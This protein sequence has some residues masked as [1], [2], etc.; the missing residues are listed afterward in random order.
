M[1]V[2]EYKCT[3]CGN[4]YEIYHPVKENKEDIVCPECK[5]NK[6]EKLFST[7]SASIGNTSPAIPASCQHCCHNQDCGMN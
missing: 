2:F 6:S 5:S 1:P 3:S 4:K 7:F